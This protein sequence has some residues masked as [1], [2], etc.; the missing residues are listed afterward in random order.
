MGVY[1]ILKVIQ[2]QEN[3]HMVLFG[4]GLKRLIPSTG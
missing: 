2:V 4:Q 3:Y 1:T